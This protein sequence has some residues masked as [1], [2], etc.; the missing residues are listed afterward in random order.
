MAIPSPP[1]IGDERRMDRPPPI[2]L[3]TRQQD[4]GKT[5]EEI[6][7]NAHIIFCTVAS[8]ARPDLVEYANNFDVAII[9]EAAQVREGVAVTARWGRSSH[10]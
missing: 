2:L 6:I 4:E 9:D 10:G 7:K 3:E 1:H 8:S 5:K